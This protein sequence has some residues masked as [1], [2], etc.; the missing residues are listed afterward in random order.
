MEKKFFLLGGHDLEMHE[1]AALLKRWG[2]TFFDRNL[3]WANA[4]MSA[5]GDVLQQYGNQDEMLLYGIELRDDLNGIVYRNYF[6]IDHHNDYCGCPASLE[7]VARIIGVDLS[8]YQKLIAAN[9]SGYIPA[10]QR[11]GASSAEVAEI[12][13]AD[14]KLQGCTPKDEQLAELSIENNLQKIGDL[15][16]VKAL[17][18]HFSPICDRLWPYRKLLIYTENSLCYYGVEKEKLVERFKMEIIQEKMY[19]GGGE[20]GFLGIAEG[21]F[22]AREIQDYVQVCKKIVIQY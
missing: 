5:Y 19:H 6:R 3:S 13:L 12:R 18:S 2:F 21:I 14:R 22:S 8:W 15:I 17:T 4:V 7:Q 16:V 9:D 1:I 10:M 11:L 20:N